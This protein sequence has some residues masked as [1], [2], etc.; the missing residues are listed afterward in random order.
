MRGYLIALSLVA[1]GCGSEPGDM[2]DD[3]LPDGPPRM[4]QAFVRE[5]GGLHLAYG[6]HPDI[7]P[8]YDDGVVDAALIGN[9]TNVRLVFDRW[10]ASETVL[11]VECRDGSWEP[12]PAYATE[13]ELAQCASPSGEGCEVACASTTPRGFEGFLGTGMPASA[14]L[15]LAAFVVECDGIRVETRH[16]SIDETVSQQLSPTLGYDSLGP[17]AELLFHGY[18][19]GS[20]CTLK[21]EQAIAPPGEAA[22]CAPAPGDPCRAGDLAG[23]RFHARPLELAGSSPVDGSIGLPPSGSMAVQMTALLDEASLA[24]VRLIGPSGAVPM[25]AELDDE[26]DGF[27]SFRPAEPLLEHTTYELFVWDGTMGLRDSFGRPPA[28]P[29]VIGFETGAAP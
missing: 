22:F 18:P 2:T 19:A 24:D 1:V 25:T 29:I 16:I 28:E 5:A 8:A 6:S 3:E 7:S 12:Y 23:V 17:A 15:N 10:F 27:V 13:A 9:G 11:Q 26:Y 4:L 14:R 21:M 20:D